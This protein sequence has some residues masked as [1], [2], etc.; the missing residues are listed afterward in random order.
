MEAKVVTWFKVDDGLHAH[1]KAI[2]AGDAMALW[3]VAGS[4]CADQLTD[5]FIPGYMVDRLSTN[6]SAHA[7]VLHRVGLW[8]LAERDGEAGFEFHDWAEMQP[9]R[10][11]VRE[12]RAATAARQKRWREARREARNG[13]AGGPAGSTRRVTDAVSNGVTDGVSDGVSSTVTNASPRARPD[14]TRP[15]P[16]APSG[17]GRGSGSANDA[18]GPARL[19]KERPFPHPVEDPPAPPP[20]PN[21][22]TREEALAHIRKTI[23]KG[24]PE[25][26]TR[27]PTGVNRAPNADHPA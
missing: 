4:W 14:P 11:Q 6:G 26:L 15:D 24:N 9:S 22:M 8:D 23:P 2:K 17:Q 3:V 13:A 12:D 21:R 25:K 18:P 7:V 19:L 10:Q 5:G 27:Y 16:T 20:D 1:P